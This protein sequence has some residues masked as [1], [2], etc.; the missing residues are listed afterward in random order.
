METQIQLRLVQRKITRAPRNQ[1]KLDFLSYKQGKT[2][3]L[4]S[5][6]FFSQNVHKNR[7]LT[8]IILENNKNFNIIFIQEPHW[9]IIHSIL[10]SM[11]EEGEM[12]VRAPYH[13]L[14]IL[15]TR[16]LHIEND[17]PRI[18]TYINI[19]LVRLHFLFRK[20]IFKGY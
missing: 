17:Y 13:L 9:S 7:L 15:F 6:K 16:S 18:L 5:L 1:R 11:S 20:D 10:S 3:I 2:M 8:D 4:K 19:K 12:I 14:W